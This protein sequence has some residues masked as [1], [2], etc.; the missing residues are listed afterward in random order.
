MG[1]TQHFASG[2]VE[3]ESGVSY[4]TFFDSVL[5]HDVIVPYAMFIFLNGNLKY[6]EG[7]FGM[8]HIFFYV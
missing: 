2:E 1:G 5:Y 4:A 6:I 3:F 8:G 7:V